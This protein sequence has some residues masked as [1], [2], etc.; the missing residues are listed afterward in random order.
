MGI[1]VSQILRFKQFIILRGP[2]F[3]LGSIIAD[4]SVAM[5]SRA[6]RRALQ[7]QEMAQ[8][9]AAA[10]ESSDED[11]VPSGRSSKVNPFD[12]LMGADED[13][14]DGDQDSTVK[15]PEPQPT[16]ANSNK[17][18]KKKR[19]KKAKAAPAAVEDADEVEA[20]I[21]EV[22]EQL[23]HKLEL[24]HDLTG[25]ETAVAH[26]YTQGLLAVDMRMLDAE[27]EMRRKFNV[28]SGPGRRAPRGR[29]GRTVRAGMVK[30]QA[31]WPRMQRT[32][33]TM[34]QSEDL[35]PDGQR[36][37][38]LMHSP[39][40][41]EVQLRFLK[42]VR[43]MDP[44]AISMVLRHHPYHI[45]SLLQL[46]EVC[47]V[48]GD[49]QTAGDLVERAIYCLQASFHPNFKPQTGCCRLNYA[50]YENRGLFL[51]LYRHIDFLSHRG[52]WRTGL[53]FNK[54]LLSL[55]PED[56]LGAI[57]WLDWFALRAGEYGYLRQ[58]AVE[59]QQSRHLDKLPNFA[60]S[61]ALA[62]FLQAQEVDNTDQQQLLTS[63]A[64][65]QLQDALMRFPSFLTMMADK[66][67]ANIR[68]D[69]LA[70][71]HFQP[72]L[73][74][75][76]SE[77]NIRMLLT[78]YVERC[79]DLWK[80][81]HVMSWLHTGA[82]ILML[83]LTTG[84]IDQVD[85]YTTERKN[86]YPQLPVSIQRHVVLADIG[87]VMA[88]LPTEVSGQGILAYDPL[89]PL[90]PGAENPY[91]AR[92]EPPVEASY[93]G[94]LLGA[95][96]QSLMPNFNAQAEAARAQQQGHA[97]PA[98]FAPGNLH[99]RMAELAQGLGDLL[100]RQAGD[101][102]ELADDDEMAAA[103]LYMP[104]EEDEQGLADLVQV[105]NVHS[106]WLTSIS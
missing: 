98:D 88:F 105:M 46:S 51:A 23:G 72:A 68:P 75:N 71:P 38:K 32:G 64:E 6:V 30:P 49:R 91:Q 95:F 96:F 27:A 104:D 56:P 79:H 69:I 20:A 74:P 58:M 77:R 9:A 40:Y 61:T 41:Q 15:P 92:L 81:E 24:R 59:W 97:M 66:C 67:H 3:A 34:V 2:V 60:F 29:R 89:P 39:A 17:R 55:S 4:S 47:K 36:Y 87:S 62:A 101:E 7:E 1:S 100:G 45:D 42:A 14:S 85:R 28:S 13:S 82:E 22:E 86:N 70:C 99:T 10:A 21:R 35:S 33:L 43:T 48:S 52:C 57:L 12:L 102:G 8:L 106:L 25:S 90:E 94:G 103:E 11:E 53:E 18:K 73:S 84:P 44:N 80:P 19:K 50:V 93:D 54:F 65:D 63:Q 37:F 83:R 78:L 16:P 31:N 26:G 5:S 76:H